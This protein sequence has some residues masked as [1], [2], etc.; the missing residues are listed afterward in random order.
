MR[1][2]P[3]LV[4]RLYRFKNVIVIQLVCDEQ[5]KAAL[6]GNV[7]IIVSGGAPLAPH[8][9]EFLKVAM[10]APVVQ[11]YGLTES[12]AASFI[13]I[14]DNYAHQATVGGPQPV[15]TF[16]LE[17]VPEM[18]YD[19][20]AIPARGEL[21]LKGGNLFQGYYKL[22]DKTVCACPTF[23]FLLPSSSSFFLLPSSSFFLLPS[24][25]FLPKKS[26]SIYFSPFI[27]GYPHYLIGTLT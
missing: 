27:S 24:S 11:G 13:A 21:L 19:A 2:D 25:F 4:L 17:S 23:L 3:T 16:A 22:P 12:C 20:L 5:M 10:C 14:P 8:V 18:K 15:T 7:R 6:G 9:E 26:G 1:R